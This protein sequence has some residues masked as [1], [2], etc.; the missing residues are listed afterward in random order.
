M[1]DLKESD[2]KHL[3]PV[4]LKNSDQVKALGFALDNQIKLLIDTAYN[5]LI[6]ANIANLPE[7]MIDLLAVELR[8][9]YY[10]ERLPLETKRTLVINT[11]KIYQK[12]GTPAAVKEMVTY[13]CGN[14]MIEEWYE[15]GGKTYFFRV[16][17]NDDKLKKQQITYTHAE[18]V[19]L[20]NTVKNTRSWLDYICYFTEINTALK[21]AMARTDYETLEINNAIERRIKGILYFAMAGT[22][23]EE[24]LINT[25]ISEKL[26]GN[27]Y[28]FSTVV[29]KE[30]EVVQ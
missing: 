28:M 20:I 3:L 6:Y 22:E 25:V 17:V 14:A 23:Y 29:E 9:M 5:S 15:Y 21:F 4:A 18:I 16:F 12:L 8:T 1:V 27:I 11:I 24:Q 2:I 7:K 10:D 19:R 13:V 26:K 30:M